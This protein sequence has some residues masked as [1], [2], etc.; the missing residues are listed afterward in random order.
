MQ[1]AL[2][3]STY[4]TRHVAGPPPDRWAHGVQ[5]VLSFFDPL[6]HRVQVSSVVSIGGHIVCRFSSVFSLG[7]H[8]IIF[9]VFA[10]VQVSPSFFNRR[11]HHVQVSSVFSIGGHIMVTLSHFFRS[12]VTGA[13]EP[14]KNCG[15]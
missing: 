12:V 7:G 11:A 1:T 3:Q 14:T 2:V 15:P 13:A 6:A 4:G 8:I 9:F 10:F 5:A